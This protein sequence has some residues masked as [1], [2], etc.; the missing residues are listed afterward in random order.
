MATG[1]NA[2]V[3]KPCSACRA[4]KPPGAFSRNRS[5]KD[6]LEFSCRACRSA[7]HAARYLQTPQGASAA[8]DVTTPFRHSATSLLADIV[9]LLLLA[10][11]GE[12]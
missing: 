10:A 12:R 2:P 3:S 8:S 4:E 7:K 11:R 6:G 9:A 5:A 1:H